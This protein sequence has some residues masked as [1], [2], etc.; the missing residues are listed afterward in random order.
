MLQGVLVRQIRWTDIH[1]IWKSVHIP[2]DT[3]VITKTN[4]I[5]PSEPRQGGG[6]GT[7]RPDANFKG[8]QTVYQYNLIIQNIIQQ[9][10]LLWAPNYNGIV[11]QPVSL[12]RREFCLCFRRHGKRGIAFVCAFERNEWHAKLS[13]EMRIIATLTTGMPFQN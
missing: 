2:W 9:Y 7:Y 8:H 6:E 1:I 12:W 3:G 10:I 4:T 5:K 13:E 11:L